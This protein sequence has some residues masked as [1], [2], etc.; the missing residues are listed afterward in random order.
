MT[1]IIAAGIMTIQGASGNSLLDITIINGGA[2]VIKNM[3][4]T[5]SAAAVIFGP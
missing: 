1:V 2:L 4:L 5:I 3:T